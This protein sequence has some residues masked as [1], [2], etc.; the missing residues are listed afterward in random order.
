MAEL[1]PSIL[2]A[3][4]SR[5]AEEILAV[6]K[7]GVR[8][9]HVDVMDG[10]FVPNITIGPP[11]VSSLRKAT[12]LKLDAHLMID[13]A[14]AFIDAFVE[15][16]ADMISVHVEACRHLHRTVTSIKSKGR[17]AGVVLNP[18]TP[19]DALEEIL[20]EADYILLMSVNPGWG[21]QK[22]IPRVKDKIVALRDRLERRGLKTLIEV[23]GGVTRDNIADLVAA[24]ADLL[25]AGSSVFGGGDPRAAAADLIARM[26]ARA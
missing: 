8:T 7:A 2:S 1:A 13:N 26:Q 17:K 11:V 12:K 9:L 20:P 10:H 25:V 24:G 16:G 4:F 14:D 21:G 3:D 6:E 22:F 23:D 15:A 19:L 5:L 18:A